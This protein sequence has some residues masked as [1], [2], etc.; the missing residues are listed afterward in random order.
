MPSVSCFPPQLKR[1][2]RFRYM[3]SKY[4]LLPWI[5]QQLLEL[6]FQTATDAFSGSGVVAYLLKSMGK[7]VHANDSLC[8][9]A[10]LTSATVANSE[11]VLD[12]DELEFLLSAKAKGV[13]E[14]FIR[15]TFEG[16]FYS[17][18]ELSA[19]D[20]LWSGIR[21]MNQPEK[22]SIALAALLRS[23][24]KRQ[25][26]GLF[27]VG[28]PNRYLDGRR[29]LQLDIRDH[30]VEQ[31]EAYNQAVFSQWNNASCELRRCF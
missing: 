24:I 20:D 7:Q 21:R 22:R 17:P 14:C 13:G 8:F 3:G 31:V 15:K 16:I 29:D 9:P 11:S 1:Y 27:T 2:P 12:T 6:E 18:A 25:P 30:F 19:L 26:R 4:R 5:H 28:D 23:A 10:V